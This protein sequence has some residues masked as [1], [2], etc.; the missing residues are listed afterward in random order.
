MG[1][2]LITPQP[3]ELKIWIGLYQQLSKPI[4]LEY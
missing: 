4:V 2:A 3:L 1:K